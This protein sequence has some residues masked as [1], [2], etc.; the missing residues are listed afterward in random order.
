MQDAGIRDHLVRALSGEEARV[1]FAKAVAGVPV[2]KRGARPPGFEHSIWQQVEH[3]R[4]AQ[5]DIL[6]FC[7][8]PAYEHTMKWPD[9]YWPPAEPADAKAWDE[10]LAAYARDLEAMKRVAR[11]TPDLSALVP[12]GKGSQ[13]YL[14]AILLVLDHTS[15]HVGQ[16]IEVRRAL[17]IWP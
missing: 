7:V 4:L 8:N 5:N 17:G 13:T 2:D 1:N 6:E 9:D 14:R 10:S 11:E 16:L 3:I 12:T 15:Y